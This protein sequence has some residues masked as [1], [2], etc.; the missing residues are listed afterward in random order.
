MGLRVSA[1]EEIRG[2]DADEHGMQGYPDFVIKQEAHAGV[3]ER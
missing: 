2:L 3:A 1:D